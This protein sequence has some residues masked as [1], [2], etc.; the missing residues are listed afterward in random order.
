MTAQ[1]ATTGR[2]ALA[3]ALTAVAEWLVEPV[4]ETAPGSDVSDCIDRPVVAVVGLHERAGATVVA[5]GLAAAF[6]AR[7]P[8]GAA[9]VTSVTGG[10]RLAFGVP[11]A[12]RLARALGAIA[13]GGTQVSGRLCLVHGADQVTLCSHLR[14]IAPLVID[15]AEHR[16]AAAAAS[17]ADG[18][19]LVAA[20]SAEPALAAV[21][22]DRLAAV[23]PFPVVVVNRASPEAEGWANRAALSLPESRL[24]ARAALSGREPHGDL[25]D[26]LRDLADRWMARP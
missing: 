24:G 26:V 3:S 20:E 8:S 17:L 14:R 22:A 23:G 10:T 4:G 11:D 16:E 9:A 18:V 19:V 6:A 21:V 5:R 12:G 25:G 7:D 13:P 15:V 1:N 2:G